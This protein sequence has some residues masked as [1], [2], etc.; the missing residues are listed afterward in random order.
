MPRVPEAQRTETL[1]PA[2]R[3]NIDVSASPDA[4]GAAIGR[5]MQQLGQGVGQ[6]AEAVQ[7]IQ[8]FDNENAAKDADNKFADWARERM[9]GEGGYLTLEGRNAVD[10]RDK[11]QKELDEK[12][13][14]FGADLKPGASR[15]YQRATDARLSSLGQQAIVHQ[16]Q[17]RKTW[18]RE[19]SEARKAT[20][21][22]DALANYT[23][24]ALVNRNIA[25]GLLEL[26]NRGQLEG[27]DGDKLKAEKASYTS[28]VHGAIVTRL[29]DENPLA[30]EKYLKDN[31]GA[32]LEVDRMKLRDSLEAPLRGAR[33]DAWLQSAISGGRPVDLG[34][35][36]NGNLVAQM[37]PIT[38]HSESRGNP[39]AV[40]PKGARGLMQVMPGTMTDPGFGIRPSNGTQADTV[41][42]GQEY[43]GKMM[44]RYGNDPA[45]AWAAYNWGP[46]NLD[47]AVSTYGAN[48]LSHAPAETRD[49]VKKNM[50]MLGKGGAPGGEQSSGAFLA[51]LYA[52]ADKIANPE[53]REAAYGA[54]DR[55]WNRQQRVLSASRQQV[56]DDLEKR[57][58]ADPSFDPSK[59]PVSTQQVIGMSGMSALQNYHDNKLAQGAVKTDPVTYDDLLT[60]QARDPESFAKVD[61][62]R[63]RGKLSDSDY[64]KLRDKQRDAVSNIDK[65]MREGTVYKDA[66]GVANEFYSAAGIKT[67][68]KEAQSDKNRALKAQFNGALR[69]EVDEFVQREKRR[70]SYDEMRTMASALTMKVIGSETRSAWSPARMFDDDQDDVWQGRVFQRGDMPAGLNKRIEPSYADVP[71]EWVNPIKTS[72]AKKLGR[73]PSNTEI[74]SEW[75]R[76]AMDMIGGN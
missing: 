45:K 72:L 59:L 12:R 51:D 23:N 75:G 21:A 57:M 36:Q 53:D 41:R 9:Y 43:L 10:A 24:P 68:G 60:Q 27:W 16:A 1:R 32:F 4:A 63:Y 42:V 37:L 11:L 66:F 62:M 34:G 17:E 55:Y 71:S 69:Q 7:K 73:A 30:A 64:L 44:E 29:I 13:R 61:L 40:S 67:T 2:Y 14:E 76:I 48:W 49:Y 54:I 58:I 18:F 31:E 3:A 47:K 70:P 33:T 8:A 28:G 26:D 20:F 35:A 5:G 38:V 65:A 39:N 15:L 52:K 50:A 19:T 6:V 22:N 74:A 46:G 56:I 25:A